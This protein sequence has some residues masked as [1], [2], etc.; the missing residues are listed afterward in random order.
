MCLIKKQENNR[1][2]IPKNVLLEMFTDS[3]DTLEQ[4]D[5]CSHWF[6][7]EKIETYFKLVHLD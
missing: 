7:R 3:V 6:Y 2:V 5:I 1:N 4:F